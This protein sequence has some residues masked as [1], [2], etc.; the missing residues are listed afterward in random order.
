MTGW[1]MEND[2]QIHRGSDQKVSKANLK[3][4]GSQ[5]NTELSRQQE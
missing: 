3:G 2:I 1:H 4:P 5:E